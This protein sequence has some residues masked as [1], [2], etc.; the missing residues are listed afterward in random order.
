MC[1]FSVCSV[2]VVVPD[3]SGRPPACR[4][5]LASCRP[6]CRAMAQRRRIPRSSCNRRHPALSDG[7][8]QKRESPPLFGVHALA[9]QGLAR[10]LTLDF[11]PSRIRPCRVVAF[12]EDG[13]KTGLNRTKPDVPF[14]I[15]ALRRLGLAHRSFL[16]KAASRPYPSVPV[17]VRPFQPFRKPSETGRNRT[18]ATNGPYSSLELWSL[19]GH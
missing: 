16:A 1:R 7:K 14:T 12:S 4:R 18:D 5:G 19:I 11:D 10:S 13:N 17:R 15:N 8:L 2:F 3:C 9:C 6:A